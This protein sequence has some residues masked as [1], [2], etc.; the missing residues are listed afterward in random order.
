MEK[1]KI[2]IIIIIN[3][4]LVCANATAILSRIA[5]PLWHVIRAKTKK[6]YIAYIFLFYCIFIYLF[7]FYSGLNERN[8]EI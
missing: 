7:I 2:K 6:D 4:N 8:F 3:L 5:P 1:Q